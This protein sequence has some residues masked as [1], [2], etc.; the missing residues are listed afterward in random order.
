[1]SVIERTVDTIGRQPWLDALAGPLQRGI[2]SAYEA[3]GGVAQRVKGALHGTWLGHPVHS[4][5]THLPIGA[6][7][8]AV[9]L[10]SLDEGRAQRGVHRA[11]DAAVGLG[12]AGA[13]AAA[14]T[15]L[16]DWQHTDGDARRT[17]LLHAMINTAALGLFTT[18][19]LLRRSGLRPAGRATALAGLGAVLVSAYLG[20]RLVYR[21][22]IGVNHADPEAGPRRWTAVLEDDD[23]REGRMR[24]VVTA[25]TPIVLCRRG[26]RIFALDAR[27]SHLGGPLDEGRLEDDSVRCPWHG[28][29]F[30]LEDGRVLESPAVYP[31]PCFETRVRDGRIEVRR[32]EA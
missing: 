2:A 28:S 16:T 17:G 13:V 25:G 31:Q 5:L 29:R 4:A 9:V 8:T 20:G 22:R 6:W 18:S 1:M 14:V 21:D 32:T 23:V 19:L 26:G 7:S 27:C 10:D 24:R 30:A 12:V 11:A 15:G 3:G